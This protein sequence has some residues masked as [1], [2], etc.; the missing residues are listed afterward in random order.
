MN[1]LVI[2]SLGLSYAAPLSPLLKFT[3]ALYLPPLRGTLNCVIFSVPSVR[4]S[5]PHS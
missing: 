1:C 2:G 3:I 4:L 5:S